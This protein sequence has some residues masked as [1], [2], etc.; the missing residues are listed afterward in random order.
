MLFNDFCDI[1]SFKY[2]YWP[3][4]SIFIDLNEKKASLEKQS[5]T[6]LEQVKSL[7][8]KSEKKDQALL[9][10]GSEI[11][12]LNSKLQS[13]IQENDKLIADTGDAKEKLVNFYFMFKLA[14]NSA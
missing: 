6:V 1:N 5:S 7:E 14:L 9:K 4:L 11:D 2:I 3:N 13:K 12:E 8:E 10:K